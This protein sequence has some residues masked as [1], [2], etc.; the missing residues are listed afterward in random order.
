MT[1]TV[2]HMMTTKGWFKFQS[3]S[4]MKLSEAENGAKL[5]QVKMKLMQFNAFQHK[6]SNIFTLK[7]ELK[8]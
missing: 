3:A 6:N 4:A 7:H 1:T 5:L 2:K 8:V